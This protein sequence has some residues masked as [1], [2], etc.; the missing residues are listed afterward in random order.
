FRTGY[1]DAF[2]GSGY[3][4]TSSR[5]PAEDQTTLF[6]DSEL[7][8]PEPQNWLDGS[9]RI[10]LKTVPRFNKYIFVEKSIR[11]C[12]DLQTLRKE[13]P[14][15]ASD[16]D[17]IHGEANALIRGICSKNWTKH[18]AVLFLDPYGMQVEWPTIEAVA[19]TQS[20]DMFLLFPLGIGVNRL[21]T[22]DAEIPHDWR[23]RL[24][25]LL[26]TSD[27]FDEFYR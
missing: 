16:I 2:A 5:L 21:L 12:D 27:W 1:I 10:A 3:R 13:F 17:I 24:D 4:T 7:A 8:E 6:A 9:A 11:R 18:R 14:A 22:R 23:R 15:M 20:I 19:R 25:L 26:G